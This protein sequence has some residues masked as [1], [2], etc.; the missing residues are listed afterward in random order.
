MARDDAPPTRFE[1]F[2]PDTFAFL[3]SDL[4]DTAARIVDF[5]TGDRIALDDRL[6]GLG[7]GAID[8]RGV[9][10]AQIRAA[11]QNERAVYDGQTGELSIDL[12]GR[13]DGEVPTLLVTIEGGGRIEAEDLLLF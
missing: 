12:D 8:V 9:T 2:G 10:Q 3:Q 4:S 1:G 11:L 7:D 5:E 13:R 6:F